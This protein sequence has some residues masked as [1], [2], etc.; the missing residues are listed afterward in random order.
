MKRKSITLILLFS[1]LILTV[2]AQQSYYVKTDTNTTSYHLKALKDGVLL[3]R[4]PGNVK[5]IEALE[6][7]L[8]DSLSEKGYK[9]VSKMLN[10]TLL[11][12][13]ELQNDI[14]NAMGS[15]YTFSDYAFFIDHNT[16]EVMSGKGKVYQSDMKTDFDMSEA[17][18][19]YVMTVGRTTEDP[20]NA[21]IILDS[22][23]QRLARP[24]P[25]Q[26]SRS[27][28]AG[29]FGNDNSHIKRLNKKLLR[30]YNDLQE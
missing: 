16:Q 18:T 22:G 27:G 11:E 3:V 8:E 10:R 9:D 25:G 26:I 2:Q 30:S 20:V 5:K 6:K 19:V 15:E 14:I 23:L 28:I 7:T 1:I 29:L 21:Y 13:E 17:S 12:T 24:F 4:L